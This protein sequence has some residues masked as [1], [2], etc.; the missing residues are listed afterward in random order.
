[1][2]IVTEPL[3]K[4]SVSPAATTLFKLVKYMRLPDELASIMATLTAAG[5]E[6]PVALKFTLPLLAIKALAA[7]PNDT[8][9]RLYPLPVSSVPALLTLQAVENKAKYTLPGAVYVVALTVPSNNLF[10]R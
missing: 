4:V 9:W 10:D 1:M 6:L 2:V 7:V 5:Q 3:A 8:N